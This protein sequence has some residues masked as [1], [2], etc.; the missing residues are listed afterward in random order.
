MIMQ[1]PIYMMFL[2]ALSSLLIAGCGT[3]A[4]DQQTATSGR[5]NVLTDDQKATGWRLLFNGQSFDGWR[6]IGRKTVPEH[7]W[8]VEDGAIRKVNTGE[9]ESLAD[10]QPAE[11]GDLMTIEAFDNFELYF[12]WRLEPG[13][14]S[15]LK[16]NVSE[17]M[18]TQYLTGYSAIGFEYQLA[19]DSPERRSKGNRLHLVGGVY[20]LFPAEGEVIV[21]SGDEMFNASRIVVNGNYVEHWLN[22]EKIVEFEFGSARLDS[23]YQLSKFK[24]YPGF[25]HKRKGHLILQ[26]HKDD[27]WFRNIRIRELGDDTTAHNELSR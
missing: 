3:S 22:G 13:G 16:Y 27:A 17:E 25:H 18:S 10:G 9:V 5:H 2:F 20:D 21:H 7:L 11:G 8:K 24:D 23:A 4:T 6:G 12:E 14:N 26:N 1:R 15:G 19:D